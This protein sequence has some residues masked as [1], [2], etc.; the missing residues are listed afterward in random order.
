MKRTYITEI[1][2]S[3]DA[4]ARRKCY[5]KITE[6]FRCHDR[7]EFRFETRRYHYKLSSCETHAGQAISMLLRAVAKYD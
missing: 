6:Y 2:V 3:K 4:G 7:G 1:S 5:W